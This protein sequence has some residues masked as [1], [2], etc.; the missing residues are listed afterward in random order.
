V[1]ILVILTEEEKKQS[2]GYDGII[3]SWINFRVGNKARVEFIERVKP[4]G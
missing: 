3:I 1:G 2:G 4:G